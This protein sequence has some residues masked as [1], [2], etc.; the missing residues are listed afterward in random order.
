MKDETN[1]TV[2]S[3]DLHSNNYNVVKMRLKNRYNQS[4]MDNKK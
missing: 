2:K 1:K 3:K 4:A